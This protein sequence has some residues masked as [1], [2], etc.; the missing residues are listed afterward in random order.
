[1]DAKEYDSKTVDVIA[2]YELADL[3]IVTRAMVA[4]IDDDER[5]RKLID[6]TDG[7][8]QPMIGKVDAVTGSNAEAIL[9]LSSIAFALTAG[10]LEIADGCPDGIDALRALVLHAVVK[11]GGESEVDAK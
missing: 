5:C 6:A 11:G 10:V 8:V 9:M 2:K 1:M 3:P 4:I 7:I